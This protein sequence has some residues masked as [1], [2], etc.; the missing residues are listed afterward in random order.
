MMT[1][2][3]CLTRYQRVVFSDV[4]GTLLDSGGGIPAS[5]PTVRESLSD[6]LFVLT[7]SRTV[8]ELL[9]VQRQL[10]IEGPFIA[11]NGSVIV[12]SNEWIDHPQG[13][14]ISVGHRMLRLIPIGTPG[15]H[16][17]AIV[18]GAADASGVV[19]ETHRD[20]CTAD[21][22]GVGPGR[23]SVT[24]HALARAHSLLLRISGAPETRL[25][26][27]STLAAAGLTISHGGRWHVV[28]GGSSKG[29]A[30][31]ALLQLIRRRVPFELCAI[32]VGDAQ[33]DRSLLE[34]VDL[35]FIMRRSDGTIEPAL[36]AVADAL[37][38]ETPGIEGWNDILPRMQPAAQH[39][40]P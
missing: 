4:D 18:R 20:V 10:G 3:D 22:P 30:V 13:T 19:I 39:G 27:F 31:R 16:L 24:S 38:A 21:V 23:P 15:T 8:E 34:A 17:A 9:A 14:V 2:H 32:G 7:S 1:G 25:R 36:A 26:F 12:L 35:R 40:R 28:Q 37:I 11:E 6:A 33:N 29:I 5:W